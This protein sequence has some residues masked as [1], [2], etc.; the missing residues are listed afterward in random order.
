MHTY[1]FYSFAWCDFLIKRAHRKIIFVFLN[2]VRTTRIDIYASDFNIMFF[3][4]L[5]DEE[6]HNHAI[7]Y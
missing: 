5:F 1:N 3:Q 6:G 7:D 4:Q 2:L